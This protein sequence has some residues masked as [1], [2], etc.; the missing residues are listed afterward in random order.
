MALKTNAGQIQTQQ[1]S[2][3]SPQATQKKKALTDTLA[4]EDQRE[5]SHQQAALRV[6]IMQSPAIMRQGRQMAKAFGPAI[7]GKGMS[8]VQQ[9]KRTNGTEPLQE[10]N[11]P[12]SKNGAV[13]ASVVQ[14]DPGDGPLVEFIQK[15][16]RHAATA[17]DLLCEQV[18][19][20]KKQVT[21]LEFYSGPVEDE[22]NT[23]LAAAKLR[24]AETSAAV[25]E[26][27]AGLP[28][29]VSDARATAVALARVVSIATPHELFDDWTKQSL[30]AIKKVAFAQAKA[31]GML[32]R[33]KEEAVKMATIA[34]GAHEIHMMRAL[35]KV[36]DESD[37]AAS[38]GDRVVVE[39]N[40]DDSVGSSGKEKAG[41]AITF[42]DAT[43][44]AV[45]GIGFGVVSALDAGGVFSLSS[46]AAT[47]LGVIGGV[48][49]LF[50]GAIGIFLGVKNTIRA[51]QSKKKLKDAKS[52]VSNSELEAI[53]E[54]AINQKEKKALR[55]TAAAVGGLAA[56]G[57]GVIGLIALSVATFGVA[58]IVAGIGAALIG[59]G[60]LGYRIIHN[61]RKR[62]AERKAFADQLIAAV[63]G[64]EEDAAQAR[65]VITGVGMDPAQA[66]NPGFRDNLA[67]KLKA[68]VK[69]KR[70]RM[71]EG[72]IKSL[73]VGKPSEVFD[74]ELILGALG[75]DA[76]EIRAWVT[77]DKANKA[78]SMVAGK[79]ASW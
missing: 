58:A 42:S 46:G 11:E 34:M 51:N 72:L 31:A 35:L 15:Q 40:G 63:Q 73:I 22:D 8:P 1:N 33:I 50:F 68:Y 14:R 9:M 29:A 21:M 7:Q 6:S 71:A 79:L 27:I 61:W 76:E 49:G 69:S 65:Q 32:V 64:G 3:A 59:L 52:K 62:K 47:A 53:A 5:S 26:H 55:N 30:A 70:T 56:I 13:P 24:I 16:G 20:G 60:I 74:S 28:D 18:E 37:A 19:A 75:L 2:A 48:L 25:R 57:A 39:L 17:Y 10:K 66:G 4:F 36:A 45:T 54:Y 67:G 41:L 77:A 44:N 78:V 23:E 43:N 12:A 38:D